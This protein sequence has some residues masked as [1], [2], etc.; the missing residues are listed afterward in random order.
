L[1]IFLLNLMPLP[2]MGAGD[3]GRDRVTDLFRW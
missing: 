2:R 1:S 3:V